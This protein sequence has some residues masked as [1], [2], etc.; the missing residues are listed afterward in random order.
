[1]KTGGLDGSLFKKQLI[2]CRT[3]SELH[4]CPFPTLAKRL[5]VHCLESLTEDPEQGRP[6]WKEVSKWKSIFIP[7]VFAA[8]L[9]SRSNNTDGRPDDYSLIT[10]F[11]RKDLNMQTLEVPQYNSPARELHSKAQS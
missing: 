2:A 7:N 4:L 11:K 9:K 10:Q 5:E 8:T 6:G 1:M 3:A